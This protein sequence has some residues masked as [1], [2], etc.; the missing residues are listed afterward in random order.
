MKIYSSILD[1]LLI[2]MVLILFK[3]NKRCENMPLNSH[4]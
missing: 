3:K 2:M 1:E 4:V